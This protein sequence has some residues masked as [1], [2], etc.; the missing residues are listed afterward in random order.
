MLKHSAPLVTPARDNK[1]SKKVFF[2]LPDDVK[3]HGRKVR[4]LSIHGNN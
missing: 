2:R 1:F 4:K 3:V